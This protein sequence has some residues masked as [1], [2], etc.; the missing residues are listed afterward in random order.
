MRQLTP[1]LRFPMSYD[2]HTKTLVRAQESDIDDGV[3]IFPEGVEIIGS[4][5]FRGM[6]GVVKIVIPKTV[7]LIGESA[8]NH[9]PD[10]E[11]ITFAPESE[12][13]SY[14]KFPFS[15]L[16]K[17]KYLSL[18]LALPQ[19]FMEC[20]NLKQITFSGKIT[21]IADNIFPTS[22]KVDTLFLPETIT[23]IAP[24]ALSDTEGL[25]HIYIDT[26]D[27]QRLAAIRNL[28]FI[29][30]QIPES[31]VQKA[32]TADPSFYLNTFFAIAAVGGFALCIAAIVVFSSPFTIFAATAGVVCLTLAGVG[33]F[34]RDCVDASEQRMENSAI[35]QSVS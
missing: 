31:L 35:K 18:P 15:C 28:L 34:D 6:P 4:N 2:E 26:Q 1:I 33:F 32:F 27:E 21:T 12:L 13:I 17:L 25:K 16:P 11:E 7:K 29:A 19:P 10:L 23:Q 24:F 14:E 20:P 22:H 3:Y 9:C 8:I 5:A 30:A